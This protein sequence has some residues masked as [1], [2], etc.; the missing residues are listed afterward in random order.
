MYG[1][2]IYLLTLQAMPLVGKWVDATHRLSI[3]RI[4]LTIENLSIVG[5][6]AAICAMVILQPSLA[7]TQDDLNN[8][9]KT[10]SK[11]SETPILLPS[12]PLKTSFY[13]ISTTFYSVNSL[14]Q[15]SSALGYY[16][17]PI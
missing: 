12:V 16:F 9:G 17:A 13:P 3:Q 7:A 6:C 5:S 2:C 15:N 11:C 8:L 1:L 4:A 10:S 14:G